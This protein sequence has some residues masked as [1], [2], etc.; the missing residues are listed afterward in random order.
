M[1]T[2]LDNAYRALRFFTDKIVGYFAALVMLG[3]TGLA[4]L[5]VRERR[6]NQR[7]CDALLGARTATVRTHAEALR[8][9]PT[10]D[11]LVTH[12][13]AKQAVANEGDCTQL[14]AA[15][16]FDR[17]TDRVCRR[18]HV[19]LPSAAARRSP[20][21]ALPRPARAALPARQPATA[22]RARAASPGAPVPL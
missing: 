7:L 2:L 6:R 13:L 22:R 9:D 4:L 12:W 20:P 15:Y 14:L 18:R 8:D 11:Y 10:G 16:D 3:A 17:P 21:P 1:D 19:S 5:D